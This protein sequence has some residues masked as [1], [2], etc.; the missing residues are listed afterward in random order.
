MENENQKYKETIKTMCELKNS[1]AIRSMQHNDIERI[2]QIWLMSNIHAH[3][4][5]EETYWK[6]QYDN[7]KTMIP[8]AEVYV[9]DKSAQIVGFIGL[10]DNYIAGL[11]VSPESQCQGIGK[12]L[13]E[14]AKRIK[15]E[16]YLNVYQKNK[17]AIQF[18][19]KEGF[20]KESESI[21][22]HTGER[23]FIMKRTNAKVIGK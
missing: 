18:Y 3:D 19:Q 4:F 5:I 16:L 20:T 7:V 6:N 13:L 11:F 21:D 12:R 10:S 17:R 2:M 8:E 9:C 23:E 15:P 14:Y 22:E 1:I